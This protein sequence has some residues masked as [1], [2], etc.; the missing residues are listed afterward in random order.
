GCSWPLRPVAAE[1]GRHGNRVADVQLDAEL[2]PASAAAGD[3]RPHERLHVRYPLLALLG[4]GPARV[5]G[6][7]DA[8]LRQPTDGASLDLLRVGRP[9][10]DAVGLVGLVAAPGGAAVQP[11][12]RRRGRRVHAGG[13]GHRDRR[14]AA[15]LRAGLPPDRHAV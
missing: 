6:P 14:D 8:D 2:L 7:D 12:P 1:S 3:R 9:E 4:A 13:Y 15:L 10:L 11:P 5:R